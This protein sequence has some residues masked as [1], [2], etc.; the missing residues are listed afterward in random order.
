M[1][2]ARESEV[3]EIVRYEKA[4]EVANLMMG[5]LDRKIKP[6]RECDYLEL[7]R[8]NLKAGLTDVKKKWMDVER[9]C[10]ANFEDIPPP[11]LAQLYDRVYEHGGTYRL[12]L[13]QFIMEFGEPRQGV[14]TGAPLHATLSFS[15]WGLQTEYPEMYLVRDL[16]ISFNTVIELQKSWKG[17]EA[18][19]LTWKELKSEGKKDAIADTKTRLH[20]HMRMCLICC[21]NLVEAYLNSIAWEHTQTED[22]SR[23]S[24][25]DKKVL[26]GNASILD[27]LAKIPKIVMRSESGPL[28]K[29]AP[30]LSEFRDLIKPYRDSIVHASPY[31]APER[32]GGYDK[33]SRIYELH[34][35]IV[36][37]AVAIT[38]DMIREIHRFIG[39]T[40]D[41]PEWVPTRNSDGT[42]VL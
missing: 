9:W 22:I 15:P 30:P 39:R 38:F 24:E 18:E 7:P 23:L 6:I 31:S 20:F 10:R 28:A 37:Q 36:Q 27:K 25:N 41:F 2:R 40:G 21:F 14:L 35:S 4:V 1:K 33:L 19:V 29:D 13:A 11:T 3:A 42:F 16:A 5:R 17:W 32:W 34:P 26:E 8:R 12:P